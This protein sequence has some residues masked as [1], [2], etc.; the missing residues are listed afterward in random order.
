MKREV[1]SREIKT[2]KKWKFWNRKYKIQ[3]KKFSGLGL[4]IKMVIKEAR[5]SELEGKSIEIINSTEQIEKRLKKKMNRAPQ[6]SV[7]TH[8]K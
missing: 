4:N 2:I 3:Y 6:T 8:S 1:L 7:G 5:I